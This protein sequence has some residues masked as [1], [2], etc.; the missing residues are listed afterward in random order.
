MAARI[1]ITRYNV[2]GDN[3][4]NDGSATAVTLENPQPIHVLW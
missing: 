1:L 3:G 2:R 4:R